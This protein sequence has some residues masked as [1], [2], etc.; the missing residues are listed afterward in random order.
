MEI[1]IVFLVFLVSIAYVYLAYK[2]LVSYFM[3]ILFPLNPASRLFLT[4]GLLGF[5][6]SLFRFNSVGIELLR[7]RILSETIMSGIGLYLLFIFL[8]FCFSILIF[9]LSLLVN[10]VSSKENEKIE[11]VKNS[12]LFAGLQ[13]ISFLFFIFLLVEPVISLALNFI[14]IKPH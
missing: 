13:S 7:D 4:I 5:G 2:I 12:F 3:A 10:K 1:G 14:K 6:F 9:R 8:S 11:L